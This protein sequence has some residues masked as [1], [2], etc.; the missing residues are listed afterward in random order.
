MPELPEVE[1]VRRGVASG[2]I[3]RAVVR[4]ELRRRDVL[5]MPG[6]PAGGFSRQRRPLRGAAPAP[7]R[8]V[9]LLEGCAVE[10]V[11]RRGKQ[12]AVVGREAGGE[13]RALIVQLGMTGHLGWCRG[14]EEEAHTH[15]LWTL[16]DGRRLAFTDPRRFGGLRSL[17]GAGALEDHWAALGP[18]ALTITGDDLAAALR[19]TKR[20]V[21]SVLLDQRAL[22]GVGNIYADEALFAS[23]IDPRARADRLTLQR[24][25]RL[26][27]SIR[28][29]LAAA[30]EAGG[31]TIRDYRSPSGESG[32]Y[33]G[34]HRVYGR[35]GESC[36]TCGTKLVNLRLAQR[37][38]VRCPICQT[39]R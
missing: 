25:E 24:V 14:E 38:T 20:D 7:V 29:V 9:D 16:D 30:V 4:I 17:V 27:A 11:E 8:G 18:D 15:A 37:A 1:T 6:D 3:G 34:T 12:I 31:S 22:A 2:L 28:D 35:G 32:G 36:L 13:E 26:A 23:G 10:R 33:Q 19:R 39:R 21:K 5:V